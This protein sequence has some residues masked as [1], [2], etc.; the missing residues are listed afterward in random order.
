MQFFPD[1]AKNIA[2]ILAEESLKMQPA[3]LVLV[4]ASIS[5]ALP[6]Q[7]FA[8]EAPAE[9][10]QDKVICKGDRSLEFGSHRRSKKVCRTASEWKLL[11]KGTQRELQAFRERA[12]THGD[13]RGR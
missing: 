3:A 8:Q 2:S 7:A 12:Q 11:E 5:L 13:A 9:N 4:V 10:P 6:A 1:C